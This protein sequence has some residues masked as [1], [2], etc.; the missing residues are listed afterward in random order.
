MFN[1]KVTVVLPIYNVEKYLNRCIQSVVNQSYNNLE[2]ILVDDGSTDRSGTLC[3]EWEKKDSRIR[4]IH[5]KNAGLGEARNSGIDSATGQY[6]CFFD[7]DDY[8]RLDAIDTAVTCARNNSSELVIWGWGVNREGKLYTTCV[9]QVEKEYYCGDEVQSYILPNLISCD[10]ENGHNCRLQMS[11][12]SMLYSMNLIKEN[13]WHFISERKIISEDVY[14]LLD[15]FSGVKS[16]S[17]IKDYLYFYCI[18]NSSLTKSYG[19]DRY[20]KVKEFYLVLYSY[21]KRK[22]IPMR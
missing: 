12:W 2:I 10:P 7:S 17:V 20:Q 6:I 14:S 15:L 21:A 18:N 9:L 11:A 1:P 19:P 13:Q 5:K 8:I 16:V 4:V 3:D 22:I